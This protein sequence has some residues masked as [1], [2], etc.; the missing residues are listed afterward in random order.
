[1]STARADRAWVEL[2]ERQRLYLSVIF[3]ADQ[4]AEAEI[5][6]ESAAWTKTP[7]ASEW[8]QITYGIKVPK[9][10]QLGEGYTSI[11][12]LL[13]QR[14]ERDPGAG[15][16]LAALEKRQLLTLTRDQVHVAFLGWC[17]RIHVRL[18]ALGRAAA[19]VGA[20]ITTPASLPRGLMARWSFAALVR[21]YLV[22]L[23][24]AGATGL[25]NGV[26]SDRAGQAPS[27]NTLLHLQDRKNGSFVEEFLVHSRLAGINPLTGSEYLE[28]VDHR[29]RLSPAGLRHYEL[30][31][32]CY[33]ELCP[34]LDAPAPAE[35]PDGAPRGLAEHRV[36]RARYLVCGT[37]LPVLVWL[38]AL[39]AT[40]ACPL[41]QRV[42]EEYERLHRAVPEEIRAVPAGLLR[43]Q[44]S[45]LTRSE[46]SIERLLT[47]PGGPLVEVIDAPNGPVHRDTHPTAVAL[48]V[49]TPAGREHYTRHLED[50][51][52]AYPVLALPRSKPA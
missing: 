3:D 38:S 7:P 16:T 46:K 12:H 34:D 52:R 10:A 6:R 32:A 13:R 11:Q 30:H 44:V 23:Y 43:R 15:S 8:R 49:L 5:K 18:T 26:S 35:R 29:V 41:R 2:N 31:R 48:I 4:A 39:E 21:L 36:R 19:R 20:G 27:W 24:L 22:R 28:R 14:G 1:M 37:D 42:I 9:N 25:R 45:D 40:G 50:Y 51:R 33:R 17:P 47:H